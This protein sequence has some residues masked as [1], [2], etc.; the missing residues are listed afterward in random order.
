MCCSVKLVCFVDFAGSILQYI[1][2][3]TEWTAS[4][5]QVT[6]VFNTC[7]KEDDS[8]LLPLASVC[9]AGIQLGVVFVREAARIRA[10]FQRLQIDTHL[11]GQRVTALRKLVR[12][13]MNSSRNTAVDAWN[14]MPGS[15]RT[16][17]KFLCSA[18]QLFGSTFGQHSPGAGFSE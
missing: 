6:L 9:A 2:H 16:Y 10:E 1:V 8:P 3:S 5:H 11:D 17:L 12:T 14:M 13:L 7:G 15:V 4:V 18:T